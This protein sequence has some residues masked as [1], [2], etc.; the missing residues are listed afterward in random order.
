[1]LRKVMNLKIFEHVKEIPLPIWDDAVK[2]IT[3]S[4]DMASLISTP[5]LDSK[6]VK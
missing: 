5:S 6:E 2:I 3:A 4:R 1:M